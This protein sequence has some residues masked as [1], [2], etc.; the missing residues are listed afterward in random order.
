MHI[1]HMLGGEGL[2]NAVIAGP[3]K[4]LLQTMPISGFVST[5]AGMLPSKGG[6]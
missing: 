6:N 1:K 4:V 3:G 5:I 2:F